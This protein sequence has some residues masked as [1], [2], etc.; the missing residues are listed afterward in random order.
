MTNNTVL[1]E[2]Q[3]LIRAAMDKLDEDLAGAKGKVQGA[4]SN[5]Q[6]VGA[7]ALGGIAA[8]A[9]AAVAGATAAI[10]TAAKWTID[11]APVEGLSQAFEGLAESAG[12][13]SDEMLKALQDGSAGMVAQ[14][15]LMASFNKAAQLVST[16]FAVQLPDAMEYLSKVSAA[17]GQDMGFMVDSLVTGVGRLSPMIL[18]NLGIQVSLAEATS[19][20]AAMF[21]VEEGELTKTQVQAGMM[22]VVL[23]KL[24][25]NTA[26][27]PDVTETAAAKMAQF[28]AQIQ[29]A[30]DRI[31]MAF[32][33]VL[34]TLMDTFSGLAERILPV[35]MK[36]IEKI[37]P[38]VEKVATVLSG[39]ILDIADGKDPIQ[40]FKDAVSEFFPEETAEKINGI[41]DGV[42]EF[43]AKV[44]EVLQPVIDWI[45]ENVKL[46]DVLIGLGIAI[47]TVVLPVI[48]SIIT[49]IAPVIATF[50]AVVAVIA[51]LRA[52]WEN[53][54]LGIRTALTEAW[55]NTIKPAL[56]QL[57]EWLSINIPLA[58]EKLKTFWETSL[59]PALQTVWAFIETNLMPIFKALG[60]FIGAVFGVY[61]QNLITS[62]DAFL[63]G[64]NLVWAFLSEY[65]FPLFVALGDFLS[66]VFE[67]AVTA[68]A[69]LWQNVLLPA[70][71]AVWSFLNES[72]FPLFEALVDFFDAVFSLALTA[73]AGL[74]ENVL[75]PALKVVYDWISEK[76]Q[77]VFETLVDFWNTV[78]LPA[79]EDVAAWLGEKLTP[80]FTGISDAISGVIGWI[81]TMTEK[82]RLIELPWWLTPGSPTPFEEGLL[83]V[84][85]ALK[86]LTSMQLPRFSAAL[87]LETNIPLGG[88]S[89]QG[90]EMM[91]GGG[92]TIQVSVD[93]RPQDEIDYELLGWRVAQEIQRNR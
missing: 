63:V 54:F 1:G 48:W 58:I 6:T 53:D 29:D 27:M 77:P 35:V 73:L 10:A 8:G 21:G 47:A 68:L 12:I 23:E 30:K 13:G 39:F 43:I 91:M 80:A 41:V 45:S 75:A 31:G 81:T 42:T 89:L 72:V 71:T 25:S 34:S 82:I 33:P 44:G 70:L 36:A 11:A 83:G 86:S 5:M 61:I 66:A 4:I 88:L 50:L 57:W 90:E 9:A 32:L 59:L 20:A 87:D 28:K 74:W 2:A 16:D 67:V 24:A 26:A 37:A 19:K 51:L 69:G 60:E 18:D 7:V 22:N 92:D 78:L 76:L 17:T 56:E 93:A 65:V 64:I 62:W 52:A 15:D 40:A 84:G 46:Q 85:D 55:E 49:A 3:V 14:R 38:V 79:I